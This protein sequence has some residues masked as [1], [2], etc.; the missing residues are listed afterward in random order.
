[1]MNQLYQAYSV[2]KTV[3]GL[4]LYCPVNKEVGQE[5]YRV[6]IKLKRHFREIFPVLWIWIRR[7]R[8]FLGLPDPHPCPLVTSTDPAQGPSII[9]QK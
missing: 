6:L 5:W 1:M 3:N 4:K 8:M 2:I 9:K 7:L